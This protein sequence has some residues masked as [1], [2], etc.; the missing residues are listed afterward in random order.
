[1]GKN[2]S[3]ELKDAL[4]LWKKVTGVN[5]DARVRRFGDWD[6]VRT[7]EALKEAI[8][9][10][11]SEITATLLLSKFLNSFVADTEVS[12]KRVLEGDKDLLERLQACRDL[13]ALIGR[14]EVVEARDAFIWAIGAALR[15]YQ[16]ADREDVK[17]LLAS[18]DRIAI[19]RRD[20]LRSIGNLRVDQFL[21]GASSPPDVKPV[22]NSHV[23][24]WVNVN[25]L[26]AASAA[27]PPGIAVNLI[28]TPSAFEAYFCFS[29]RNGANLY[30]LSDVPEYEHPLQG[31]MSRRPDRALGERAARNWFPYDL[32][33][34][35]FDEQGELYFEQVES[36]ALAPYQ[37]H[38][39]PLKKVSE[40]AANELVW[41]IM[42]F[43]LIKEK[44]WRAGYQAKE[45]SYTAEMLKSEQAL[46][47]VA[48]TANLPVGAY[49]PVQLAPL[50]IADVLSEALPEG[51]IGKAGHRRNRWMEERYAGKV[52]AA[53]VNLVAPPEM[54][55]RL[56]GG[57]KI[58]SKAT[59]DGSDRSYSFE[60]DQGVRLEKVGSSS[61]GTRK[62]LAQDRLF[63]ARYNL[64]GQV[65]RL[66]RDEFE[67]RKDEISAW[68]KK[69]ITA[70][71]ENL[72]AWAANPE[73]WIGGGEGGGFSRWHQ[74]AG[75][76]QQIGDPKK[77]MRRHY[78]SL[79]VHHDIKQDPWAGA[80][81]FL[82]DYDYVER[83]RCYFLDVKAS[84]YV[85][86]YPGNARELALFAGCT[87]EDLPDVLRHFDLFEPYSGN[88]ILDRIDP[89]E[90][91]A[92]NPWKKMDF[93]IRFAFSKRG[94]ADLVRRRRMP[95]LEGA[96][97]SLPPRE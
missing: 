10:D 63:I 11:S 47:E 41:L 48:K 12:L 78:R 77:V 90:W 57:G 28:R 17:E 13:F 62:T 45:L 4:A 35:A 87:V 22:Y 65:D 5:P 79:V 3:Q 56:E 82:P 72:V 34:V 43:D 21:S 95:E 58:V 50:A 29:I 8:E 7:F 25:S 89:M 33:G 74:H 46:I 49:K 24:S 19:L 31:R 14:E 60:E 59:R 64:A 52:D 6:L 53:T 70:N 81:F 27:M 39:I 36:R 67:G 38:A 92:A 73:I 55:F 66:A 68:Y 80:G 15:H 88:Q 83:Q 2:R 54:V 94:M 30:V 37:K 61:F 97:A 76:T 18:P 91:H 75:P 93:R 86:L 1:M 9:L 96:T 26:L 85:V 40:L 84:Y 23:H 51:A 42:M 71:A 20:A 69:A 16:A 32:L 44:F